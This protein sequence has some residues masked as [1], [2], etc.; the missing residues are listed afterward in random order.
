MAGA[1]RRIVNRLAEEVVGFLQRVAGVDSDSDADRR[2]AASECPTDLAL[3]RLRAGDTPSRAREREHR[4]I[5]LCLD[6]GAAVL[7]GGLLDDGVVSA[8]EVEPRLGT[9]S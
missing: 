3:D 9:R 8:E 5:A 7:R 2:R 6:D 1:T 4:S